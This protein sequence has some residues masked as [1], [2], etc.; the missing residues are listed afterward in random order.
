MFAEE[1]EPRLSSSSCGGKSYS[2]S[3]SHARLTVSA[4]L[5]G[6]CTVGSWKD[7][8]LDDTVGL[9]VDF[10][11]RYVRFQVVTDADAEPSAKRV[12]QRSAYD[13]LLA[14]AD[15]RDCLPPKRK[16]GNAKDT[17]LNDV[18]DHL[19]QNGMSFSPDVTSQL[20]M[21]RV[22][23]LY[24]QSSTLFGTWIHTGR[25]LFRSALLVLVCLPFQL[26]GDKSSA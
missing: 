3:Q 19:E 26:V 8:D 25:R 12:C 13:V 10:G 9:I 4:S 11:C 21:E 17:L 24:K 14:A 15:R 5:G 23:T 2:N 20:S 1:I 18:L 6:R 7:V 22:A 16:G